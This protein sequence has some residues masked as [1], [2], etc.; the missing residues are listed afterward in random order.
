M[1]ENENEDEVRT[2]AHAFD[3]SKNDAITSRVHCLFACLFGLFVWNNNRLKCARGVRSS[4]QMPIT[5]AYDEYE[6]VWYIHFRSSPST[7]ICVALLLFRI[8]VSR[9]KQS[10]CHS[11]WTVMTNLHT[12]THTH[13]PDIVVHSDIH[14]HLCDSGKFIFSFTKLHTQSELI[15][16][17]ARARSCPRPLLRIHHTRTN[18]IS[19]IFTY[20]YLSSVRSTV[21]FVERVT[22]KLQNLFTN[23]N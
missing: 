14:F 20:D 2:T 8:F 23:S 11:R 17:G 15:E 5:R 6:S 16:W 21:R 1:A 12:H 22:T 3:G 7:F 19:H 13:P 9:Q 4:T 10:F 18:T